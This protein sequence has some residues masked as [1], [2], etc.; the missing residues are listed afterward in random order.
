MKKILLNSKSIIILL[1]IMNLF[2]AGT[3]SA[4]STTWNKTAGG[5]WATSTNWSN[6][7]PATGDD[8]II[9]TITGAATIT[10]VPTITLNS[11]AINVSCTLAGSSSPIVLTISTTFSVAS[12]ITVIAGPGGARVEI[13]LAGTA[14]G[15][16]NG[17]LNLDPATGGVHPFICNGTVILPAA[18]LINGDGGFTL[19]ATGTIQIGS[20]AGIVAAGTSGNI[21]VTGLIVFPATATYI[22]NGTASQSTGTGLPTSLTGTFTIN[23][24]GNTVTLGNAETVA[25][26]GTVNIVAGTFAAGTNLTM[27]STS[28]ITRSGGTMTGTPAGAGTYNVSYTGSSITATTELAGTGL[29]NVTVNLTAAQNLT[30]NASKSIPGTLTLTSGSL[31]IPTGL[32]FTIANGTAIGGSGFASNHQIVTQVNTG[33]GAQGFL[34]V[35]SIAANSSYVFPVGDGINY[36]PVT[37]TLSAAT[38]TAQ[39]S[40]NVCSFNGITTNGA[41]NGTA[42]NITQKNKV[43]NAVWTVNYNGTGTPTQAAG[44]TTMLLG[45]PASLEGPAFTLNANALIGIAHYGPASWG[46]CVGSGDNVANTATR[47]GVTTFSPFGVGTIDPGGAPL[48]IKIYYFNASKG[49]AANTLNWNADCSS[50]QATFEIERSA[51]GTNF[52]TINSITASQAR[53]ALPFSY[54]DASPLAGNNFY[55]IK[56]IDI[57]GRVNYTSIV[58]VGGQQKDMQLVGVLPNPVSNTAQLNITTSKKE[59]V[60]LAVISLEGAIVYKKSVQLQAGS[61]YIN[62]EIANLAPGTYL[63]RG[64]FG[65]GQ[66]NAVKFIKQ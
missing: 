10:A 18:G 25:S 11:L 7:V 53:C 36:L 51:D 9:N 30:L 17:T 32:T 57:N 3:V 65:D 14:T 45:W 2:F 40:F 29:N 26:G 59:N 33:T 27:A 12:G 47:T 6:G 60:E 64:V 20:T 31:I 4:K 50:T 34:R 21:Q 43:V 15:T 63:V 44:S 55:R 22:Y 5:S 35:N 58:R 54:D 56:I 19:G 66:T 46:T 61:S 37:L 8:V 38:V 41:P 39:N 48:P 52:T 28:S 1:V 13:T 23:N 42:F 24:P 49:T 16:I 62:L